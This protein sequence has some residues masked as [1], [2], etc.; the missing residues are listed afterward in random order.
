MDCR[1][2]LDVDRSIE[3]YVL[4][5]MALFVISSVGGLALVA[6][7]FVRLPADYFCNS[8]SRD[9]W[10]G[11]HP[12]IR[13]TGLVVKNLLG[14]GLVALGVVLVLP[15]VPGPGILTIL[16][17]VML[18]DFPGKRRLER[19]LIGRPTILGSVNSLRRRYG[20]APFAL[21]ESDQQALRKTGTMGRH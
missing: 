17:G 12:V 14:V 9:F 5:G 21:P 15:G 8:S 6:F 10:V 20:K 2:R 19:R 7:L 3:T 11:R 16:I 13:R 18:L 1:S 4:L